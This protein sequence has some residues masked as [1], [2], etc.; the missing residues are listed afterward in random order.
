MFHVQS[1]HPRARRYPLV[2]SIELTDVESETQICGH[3]IELSLYGCRVDT[4]ETLPRG[5]RVRIR[6]VHAGANFAALGRVVYVREN[7]KMGVAFT[8][9]ELNHETVLEKWVDELRHARP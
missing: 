8:K 1:E 7:V 6:I 2:A 4:R 3:T 5:A 9:I